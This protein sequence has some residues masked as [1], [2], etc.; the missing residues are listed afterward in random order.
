MS[1]IRSLL[2]VL[3]L[4]QLLITWVAPD[5]CARSI[6]AYFNE[7]EATI[8]NISLHVGE[9]FTIDL[10]MQPDDDSFA[11]AMLTEP[12]RTIAYDRVG[13][14]AIGDT[15]TRECS[16]SQPACFNWTLAANENWVGGVA[17]VNIYCQLNHK[18][19]TQ[20]YARAYFTVV[21]AEI[22]PKVPDINQSVTESAPA[23]LEL[24]LALAGIT[25]TVCM[26]LKK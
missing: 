18:G 20:P 24:F 4:I 19:E 6:K 9:P 5:T 17:P 1:V 13:G 10:F 11:Y 21:E 12:G 23:G 22:L 14:D 25:A 15:V 2:L 8:E 3:L 26:R 16:V 7:Q